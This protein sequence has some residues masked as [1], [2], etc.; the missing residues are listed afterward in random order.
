MSSSGCRRLD[1]FKL[2]HRPVPVLDGGELQ[3]ILQPG[4]SAPLE[5]SCFSISPRACV[6]WYVGIRAKTCYASYTSNTR[7][8]S[9]IRRM[10]WIKQ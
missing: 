1:Q 8:T 5:L 7:M 10:T 4:P 3:P 2:D 6:R 9:N